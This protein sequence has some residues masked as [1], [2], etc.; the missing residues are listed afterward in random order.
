MATI[1]CVLL[2]LT[3]VSADITTNPSPCMASYICG[4]YL[5]NLITKYI[6]N[7]LT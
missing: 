7:A 1:I 3:L 6:V 2:L 5:D 4:K